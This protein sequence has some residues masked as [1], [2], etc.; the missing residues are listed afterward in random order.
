MVDTVRTTLDVLGMIFPDLSWFTD[1]LGVG[2][3]AYQGV[4]GEPGTNQGGNMATGDAYTGTQVRDVTVGGPGVPEP[5]N[6]TVV[7]QW[8]IVANSQVLNQTWRVYFFKLADGRTMCYN[9]MK[10]E[11]KIWK[12]KKSIVIS[13]NPRVGDIRKAERAVQGAEKKLAKASDN[14]AYVGTKKKVVQPGMIV[15]K[16]K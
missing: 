6:V 8:S 14:L 12:A 5:T 11:W 2:Y 4:T 1:V 10:K 9:P 7:K 16:G 3:S 15:R 13:S